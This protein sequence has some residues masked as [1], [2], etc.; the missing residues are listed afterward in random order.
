ME[1]EIV[2]PYCKKERDKLGDL[3]V[4]REEYGALEQDYLDAVDDLKV[5]SLEFGQLLEDC[6]YDAEDLY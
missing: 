3:Y 6:T 5:L 1:E 2:C 4:P